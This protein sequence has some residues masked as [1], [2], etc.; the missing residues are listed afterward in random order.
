[1]LIEKNLKAMAQIEGKECTYIY[2]LV[3]EEYRNQVAYGIEVERQDVCEDQLVSL[4]RDSVLKIS[5]QKNKVEELLR[6]LYVN[7]VS[8]IHLVDIVGEYADKYSAD[9]N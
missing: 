7:K 9:F 2:R 1:M 4:E 6:T 8:P 5:N 3:K